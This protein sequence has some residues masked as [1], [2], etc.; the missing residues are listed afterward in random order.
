MAALNIIQLAINNETIAI[1]PNSFSFTGGRGERTVRTKMTGSSVSTVIS[2]DVE[3]QKSMVK[4]VLISETTTAP[5]VFEWQD[6][7]DENSLVAIDSEGNT[8]TFNRA[9][10]ITDPEINAAVDAETAIEFESQSVVSGGSTAT[11]VV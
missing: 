4:F 11:P 3:T 10:L 8:Y 7:F 6:R 5:K 9:I 1:K 2:T